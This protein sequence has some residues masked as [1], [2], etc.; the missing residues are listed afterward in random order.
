MGD[1]SLETILGEVYKGEVIGEAFFCQMLERFKDPA[2]QFKSS[3]LLQLETELKAQLRPYLLTHNI[4]VIE[5]DDWRQQGRDLAGSLIGE[6]WQEVMPQFVELMNGFIKLFEE[7]AGVVG[8]IH[9]ELGEF[10]MAHEQ[11]I[12]DFATR[13]AA[14]DTDTSIDSVIEILNFPLERFDQTNAASIE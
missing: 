11:S 14:G 1:H 12:H 4:P 13:E 7:M 10:M 6:S 5:Q 3:C 9:P 8:P 2:D